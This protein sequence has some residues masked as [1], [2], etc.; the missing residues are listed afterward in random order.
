MNLIK[1]NVYNIMIG[2]IN[3]ISSEFFFVLLQW[4]QIWWFTISPIAVENGKDVE[5]WN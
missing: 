4:K 5:E 2:R 1:L 3:A